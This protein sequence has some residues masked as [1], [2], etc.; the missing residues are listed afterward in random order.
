MQLYAQEGCSP[1]KVSI[2][3]WVQLPLWLLLS[4]ALRNMSGA[5]PGAAPPPEVTLSMASE[6]ALWIQ[7]LTLP[8]PLFILPFLLAS[9][10]LL[11][12]EVTMT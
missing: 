12:I 2:L 7:D 3:P 8:D 4:L 10:N 1:Y 5:F 9:T 11:N 6:G